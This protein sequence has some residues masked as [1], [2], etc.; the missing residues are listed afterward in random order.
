MLQCLNNA[1]DEP[2]SQHSGQMHV[3]ASIELRLCAAF[4]CDDDDNN[5]TLSSQS[6][7]SSAPFWLPWNALAWL[8]ATP[9]APELVTLDTTYSFAVV[10]RST[11][12]TAWNSTWPAAT[13]A[14]ESSSARFA[15][16]VP[17]DFAINTEDT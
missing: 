1:D 4:P 12:E 11:G 17:Q 15:S 8:V 5:R 9:L 13:A 16:L 10:S 3:P 6:E 7:F 2:H 14:G